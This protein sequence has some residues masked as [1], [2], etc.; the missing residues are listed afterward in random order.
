MLTELFIF[1]HLCV[2]RLDGW[3]FTKLR[4]CVFVIHIVTDANK[5]LAAVCAGNQHH[6]YTNSITFR[7]QSSVRR[8]SLLKKEQNQDVKKPK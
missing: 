6:S 3:I 1:S 7:D 4:V 5:L 8:I 2:V